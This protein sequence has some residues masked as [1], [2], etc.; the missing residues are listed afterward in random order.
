[1]T[2]TEAME[3]AIAEA[4]QCNWPEE[5]L[6]DRP[7]VGAVVVI[8]EQKFWA[9]HRGEHDHAEKLALESVPYEEDLTQATVFTTLEPCTR[10]VRTTEEES[11]TERL[12]RAQVKK[13]VVGILDPNQGVCGKGLVELQKTKTEIK[14]FP[15]ALAVRISRL[16][17]RFIR[18]QQTLGITI[19]YPEKGDRLSMGLHTIK[20][21]F[22]NP[23]DHDVIAM[24]YVEPN[25]LDGSEGGWWPQSPV[26]IVAENQWEATVQFGAP[27]LH[28]VCIV[29]AD[30]LGR[31]LVKFYEEL[32]GV[33]DRVIHRVAHLFCRD[34]DHVTRNIAPS[35]WSLPMSSLPPKGLAIQAE[36]SISVVAGDPAGQGKLIK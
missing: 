32:K 30:K 23:P 13:V 27:K 34:L 17:D 14:L 6:N 9:A 1:M 16:N 21:R 22:L 2:E 20:G 8:G 12:I 7:K 31:E 3:L 35:F 24:T 36:V 10:G 29:R 19:T 33:R 4:E 18:A 25:A 26:T 28:K 11:C 15:H 5:A